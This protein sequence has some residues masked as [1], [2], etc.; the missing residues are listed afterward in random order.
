MIET[1]VAA[2]T[3]ALDATYLSCKALDKKNALHMFDDGSRNTN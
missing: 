3:F 2:G 1:V